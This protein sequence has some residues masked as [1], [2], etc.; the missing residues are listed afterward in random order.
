M[1]TPD[2]YCVLMAGGSGTR[3]WPASRRGQPKQFLRIGGEEPLLAQTWSRLE[4]FVP[5]ERVLVVTTADQVAQVTEVLPEL[6][7]LNLLVEPEARNTGPCVALAA[8]EI[9][10]RSPDSVQIVLPADHVIR[11]RESF[12]RTLRAAAREAN[13][14]GALIVC[15]IQP[16]F[17]ATGFGYIQVAEIVRQVDG[18]SVYRVQRFVEKPD[19]A[20]AQAFLAEGGYYWNAG[21][22]VWHT[23]A[24]LRA[25]ERWM[26]ETHAALL[27][28]TRGVDIGE[29]YRSLP[30][31]SIDV[32][33]LER[34][35]GVRMIPIDYF[36]SDVGSWSSLAEVTE[37]S[38]AGNSVSGGAELVAE[39][40]SG[41]IVHAAEGEVVALLG[42]SDLIV[43]HAGKA[44][45]V[46][47]RGRAQ[48]VRR[49]VERLKIEAPDFL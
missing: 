32:G 5:P 42:V 16:T 14:S 31:V 25:I 2:L 6:P 13:Q 37:P 46:L 11:P 18:Q 12:Q 44:T 24:I 45:L 27:G 28:A 8:H 48:D 19:A 36:W 35:T 21:I 34:A 7:P 20:R 43:V 39:E 41:C 3:F 17:P 33:V 15:G 49:I 22:F 1:D 47:P 29:I 26:P 9:H 38:E 4:D 10:R 30:K 23:R 40:S